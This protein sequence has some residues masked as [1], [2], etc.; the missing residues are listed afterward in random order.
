MFKSKKLQSV[1]HGF[2]GRY[3]GVSTGIYSSLNLSKKTNDSEANVFANRALVMD[4]LNISSQK[5]FFP[6]QKHTKQCCSH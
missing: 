5:I 1:N 3:G 4:R 6:N 2:F